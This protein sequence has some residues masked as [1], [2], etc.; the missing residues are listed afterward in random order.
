MDSHLPDTGP[1]RRARGPLALLASFAIVLAVPSLPASAQ[2]CLPELGCVP[3]PDPC[4]ADP[5][6]CLP[7]EPVDQCAQNPQACVADPVIG[8]DEPSR[9]QGTTEASGSASSRQASDTPSSP[10]GTDSRAGDRPRSRS[11]ADFDAAGP[12]GTAARERGRAGEAAAAPRQTAAE[13]PGTLQRIARAVGESGRRL[14]F[15]IALGL[16]A[17]AFLLVQ[18]RIDRRDPKLALA[19]VDS[20]HDVLPFR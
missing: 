1:P 18:G 4:L 8:E 15:P 14:A 3:E 6:S 16:F 9:D 2:V 10:G 5:A 7:D 13:A 20:R 19:P 11:Q 12:V 17:T